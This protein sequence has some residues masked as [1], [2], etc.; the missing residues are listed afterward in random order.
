DAVVVNTMGVSAVLVIKTT[1][2]RIHSV[3]MGSGIGALE[4]FNGGG[5]G[6]EPWQRQY[7]TPPVPPGDAVTV[8]T[9]PSES[10]LYTTWFAA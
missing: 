3:K 9:E 4:V 5:L 7:T 8:S 6:A 10:G 1:T 2:A